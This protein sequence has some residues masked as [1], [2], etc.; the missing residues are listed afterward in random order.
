MTKPTKNELLKELRAALTSNV[1]PTNTTARTNRLV[2][3]LESPLRV[4]VVGQVQTDRTAFLNKILQIDVFDPHQPIPPTRIA[5]GETDETLCTLGNGE[6]VTFNSRDHQ[7]IRAKKVAF[8]EYRMPTPILK[9]MEF[10][11]VAIP[12]I[13]GQAK[14]A[15][16]WVAGQTDIMIWYTRH[17]TEL[18]ARLWEAVPEHIQDHSFLVFSDN[19]GKKDPMRFV[20]AQQN[21][22]ELFTEILS[23]KFDE[24]NIPDFNPLTQAITTHARRAEEAT[25]A[26][27]EVLLRTHEQFHFDKSIAKPKPKSAAK[28]TKSAGTMPPNPA[29]PTKSAPVLAASKPE[30][31]SETQDNTAQG[32]SDNLRG[33]LL[34]TISKISSLG[35]KLLGEHVNGAKT[36][37]GDTFTEFSELIQ[38]ISD[39]AFEQNDTSDRGEQVLYV[40]NEVLELLQLLKLEES[41]QSKIDALDIMNQTKIELELFA[42][43]A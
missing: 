38:E 14:R 43:S 40:A 36:A 18:E 3:R 6:I 4:S 15:V 1:M 28:D 31:V 33:A 39:V 16:A 41:D 19:S 22:A 34:N 35:Q 37:T 30:P 42:I 7:E 26:Q 11:S 32:L 10:L 13:E 29:K 25:I 20:T 21:N 12:D 8:V 2:D 17:Y 9:S 27:A 23:I 24:N 5:Y